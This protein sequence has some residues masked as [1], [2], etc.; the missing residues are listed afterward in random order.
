MSVNDETRNRNAVEELVADVEAYIDDWFQAKLPFT[1]QGGVRWAPATDVFETEGDYRVTM[2]IPGMSAD[3]IHVQ[4]ERS[5]LRVTGVR[6]EPCRDP[7]RYFKME[8][9]VGP[10]ERRI[11]LP[12]SIRADE[13]IVRYEGGLLEIVVPK[14]TPVDVPI[15]TV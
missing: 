12:R 13:I 7:R 2:A 15:D 11:R 6:R 1:F 3:D 9:P 5:V 4:L 14:T 8:I 10:F